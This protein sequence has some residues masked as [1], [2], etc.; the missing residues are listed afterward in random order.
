M[1]NI[2][3]YGHSLEAIITIIHANPGLKVFSLPPLYKDVSPGP[4][5]W[6]FSFIGNNS[7]NLK[8]LRFPAVLYQTRKETII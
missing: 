5:L 3:I 4:V 8:S 2:L 6:R 7:L 1:H